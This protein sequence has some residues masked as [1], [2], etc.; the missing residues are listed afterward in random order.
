MIHKKT[1]LSPYHDAEYTTDIKTASH[2][3]AVVQQRNPEAYLHAKTKTPRVSIG[4]RLNMCMSN[5]STHLPTEPLKVRDFAVSRW[6]ITA[7][8]R[9]TH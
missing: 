7:I 9:K 3:Y 1:L 5:S 2:L 6:R 4:D 8:Q